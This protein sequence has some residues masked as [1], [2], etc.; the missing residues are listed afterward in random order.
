M[1][2][3]ILATFASTLLLGLS[4][5]PLETDASVKKFKNCTELNKAYKGGIAK[6][7][8]VKNKG[9]KTKYKPTVSA[10]LYAANESKDRDKD[11]IACER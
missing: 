6:N 9:G 3:I 7:S 2:K 4:V 5:P 11:G 8:K 10:K 1:K